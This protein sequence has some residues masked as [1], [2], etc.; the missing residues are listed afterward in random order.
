A[1]ALTQ[2]GFVG[3]HGTDGG[4]FVTELTRCGA[5]T[6]H[7]TPVAG[8]SGRAMITVTP[9]GENSI[10]V[11]PEANALLTPSIVVDA[12]DDLRPETI[13]TQL[14]TPLAAVES[15]AL[16]ATTNAARFVLNASP[17]TR[18]SDEIRTAADPLIVNLSEAQDLTGV[19]DAMAAAR[20]LA[21]SCRSVII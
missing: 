13:L 9:D 6:K 21:G 7:F 16:W 1:A 20:A 18:L 4:G 11:L 2:T 3:C 8:P 17:S 19:H 14:E 5:D 12:L 10:T 15:A